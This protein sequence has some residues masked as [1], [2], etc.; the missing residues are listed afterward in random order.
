MTRRVQLKKKR[1]GPIRGKGAGFERNICRGFSW[2]VSGG[3][4]IDLFWRTAMSGGRATVMKGKVRQSG[5]I[6]AVA[7]EGH[8]FTDRFFIECKHRKDLRLDIF[9]LRGTG[10]IA[11]FWR[12]TC[13][14]ANKFL[15][16]IPML[17]ARPNGLPVFVIV[18]PKALDK[19]MVEP[20]QPLLDVWDRKKGKVLYDIYLFE[21]L[22]KSKFK[23]P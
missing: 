8:C 13:K 21:D 2:W 5:D 4:Y 7:P 9:I 6:T 10:V 14:E 20:I 11:D 1:R 17:V 3:K 16:K 15:L 12:K 19:F 22:I 18:P 23:E